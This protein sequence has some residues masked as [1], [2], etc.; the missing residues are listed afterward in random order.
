MPLAFSPYPSDLANAEQAELDMT[1]ACYVTDGE[2]LYRTLGRTAD[3]IDRLVCV[4]DCMSLEVLL[5]PLDTV[6]ALRLVARG[7]AS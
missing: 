1:S 7:D 3:E 4:E 2:V 6:L 5:V